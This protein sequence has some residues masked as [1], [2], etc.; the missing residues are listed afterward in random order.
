MFANIHILLKLLISGTHCL[1]IV[2]CAS[3]SNVKNAL[4]L[5][6]FER[7]VRGRA[8]AVLKFVY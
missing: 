3:L 2:N 8:L 7:F 1:I 5:F 4:P 6:N